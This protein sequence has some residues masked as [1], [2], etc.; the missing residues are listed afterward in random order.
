M[1]L[2]K[3][4]VAYDGTEFQGFQRQAAGIRTVQ[5]ELEAALTKLGWEQDSL[6]AAGRTDSGVHASGQVI[7]FDLS[8]EHGLE[9]L[10]RAL[11]A[12][13]PADV[14]VQSS[15]PAPEGFHPRFSASSRCY[16]YRLFVSPFRNPLMERF[17]LRV[18]PAPDVKSMQQ[19][20]Q[21][22]L[23]RMDYGAFGSAPI[24]G[25]HT[26]REVIRAV[27]TPGKDGLTFDIEGDA[28]LK[29]MVRRL[30]AASLAVGRGEI[31]VDL[32]LA[33]LGQ[34]QEHWEGRLAGPQGLCLEAVRYDDR[35]RSAAIDA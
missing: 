20:A 19:L 10:T 6:Q 23:G 35:T 18:W 8:W 15:E 12:H 28:F 25:G 17:A 29:N 30:V 9:T 2:Y 13:L 34:S 31:P 5:G 22:M 21:A 3:S 11:N 1:A 4:I 14:A 16:R 7:S 24:Q 32:P 27:W 33:L 26:V